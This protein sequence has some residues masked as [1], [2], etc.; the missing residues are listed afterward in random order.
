MQLMM[1]N[2]FLEALNF[3]NSIMWKAALKMDQN[4][5]IV[6]L[7]IWAHILILKIQ[8]NYKFNLKLKIKI[9]NSTYFQ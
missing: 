3:G 2:Y 4:I 6:S 1:E 8:R 9:K 7:S 5:V